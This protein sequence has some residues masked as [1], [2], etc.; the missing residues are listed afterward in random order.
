MITFIIQCS[1]LTR[2]LEI[3]SPASE[4]IDDI[5]ILSQSLNKR[6]VV[7]NYYKADKVSYIM[8]QHSKSIEHNGA[9]TTEYL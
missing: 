2:L 4:K 9:Q 3:I 5:Y 6:I 1:F 7:V 8:I